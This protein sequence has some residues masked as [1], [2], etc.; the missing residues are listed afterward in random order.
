MILSSLRVS[1]A[2]L[3]I[4]HSAVAHSADD[5]S[6]LVQ[7][8]LLEQQSIFAISARNFVRTRSL[9]F[10]SCSSLIHEENFRVSTRQSCV[11]CGDIFHRLFIP[12]HHLFIR[13]PPSLSNLTMG[14]GGVQWNGKWTMTSHPNQPSIRFKLS[15][16]SRNMF[17]WL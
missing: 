15:S 5:L 6:G 2:L 3:K 9:T 12:Y 11:A 13:L 16:Q 4:A 8:T 7:P 1:L 17:S 10:E 14:P